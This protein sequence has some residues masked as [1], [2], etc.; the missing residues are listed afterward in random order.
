[1]GRGAELLVVMEKNVEVSMEEIAHARLSALRDELVPLEVEPW[2]SISAWVA[3]AT[4]IIRSDWPNH[5]D[6]FGRL[7]VRPR[8][9]VSAACLAGK[10]GP[11]PREDAANRQRADEAKARL[12]SFCDGL[13][14]V[15]QTHKEHPQ[16]DA[17]VGVI[18]G[19]VC[20]H[21]ISDCA[22]DVLISWSK[23]QSREMASVFHGWLP[24]VVPGLRPWM[25]SKD[26]DKGRLWFG[27][28]QDFLGEAT[29]C[30]ICVTGEN[31]RSPWIYYETGAIAAKKQEV[32]VCPYL[33]GIGTS[34]IADGPL[35]QWQCT[36]TTKE[37]TLALIRSL[38]KALANPHDEG[39]LR[40]NFD[41]RW[42]EFEQELNRILAM[43][44]ASPSD[45]VQTE[46]DELAGYTLSSEARTLLVTAAATDGQVLYCRSSSGYNTQAGN[47]ILNEP[48]NARS[49]A[50]WEQAIKDLVA[51]GLLVERGHKGQ[52][53]EV[54]A[55]GYEVV[56]V[57]QKQT[58]A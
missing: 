6:D 49:E 16:H 24:K 50:T 7:A 20:A 4:P 44:A 39:L 31:V 46:A 5:F 38:N 3:K 30:I 22:M 56:D 48:H 29:S 33:V 26:I 2:S 19:N 27:E 9:L 10:C 1:M 32:L 41:S 36:E 58:D 57:L 11:T 17:P 28:L 40:G 25:S 47:Q 21:P 15:S 35:V 42:P 12:L 13:L 51:Y 34:M 52:V 18:A 43:E 23:S 8:T 14:A 53:F 45:F 55:K 37:D 54:T